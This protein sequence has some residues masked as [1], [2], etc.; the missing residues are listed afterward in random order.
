MGIIGGEY[1]DSDR[2]K[3]KCVSNMCYPQECFLWELTHSLSHKDMQLLISD[4]LNKKMSFIAINFE[5]LFVILIFIF[6][7][8][9]SE[10]TLF[11]NNLNF[12]NFCGPN[13]FWQAPPWP[14][15]DKMFLYLSNSLVSFSIPFPFPILSHPFQTLS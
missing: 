4:I 7:T 13:H 11:F 15:N 6:C 10:P 5:D 12:T 8:L 14:G 2:Y 3:L 1:F 9:F